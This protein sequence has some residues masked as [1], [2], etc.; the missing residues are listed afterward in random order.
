MYINS[1]CSGESIIDPTIA[2]FTLAQLDY[3]YE[4]N[5][6]SVIITQVSSDIEIFNQTCDYIIVNDTFTP[7][8]YPFLH[9]ISSNQSEFSW[10]SSTTSDLIVEDTVSVCYQ[11][12]FTKQ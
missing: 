6:N 9:T 2:A 8:C 1:E 4:F 3:T 10:E 11:Y 5:G 12:I 7:N